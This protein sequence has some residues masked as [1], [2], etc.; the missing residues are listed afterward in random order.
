[1]G[2]EVSADDIT[3]LR[4]DLRGESSLYIE[5][6][7]GKLGL[8]CVIKRI[9]SKKTSVLPD[10]FDDIDAVLNSASGGGGLKFL[11]DFEILRRRTRIAANYEAFDD[12]AC[13]AD[14]ALKNGRHVEDTS[15]F[16]IRLRKS[17][18]AI[19]AGNPSAI[20]RLKFLYLFA[21]D[22]GYPVK[23]DFFAGLSGVEKRLFAALVRTP[24]AELFELKA[25]SRGMLEKFLEWL[26]RSTDIIA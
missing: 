25:H 22:E 23:E 18:D 19:D 8:L 12:A 4:R 14:V 17:F 10:I 2:G 5:A 24:S 15:K 20:V 9:S 21:R 6:F 3:V 1:M 7:S 26:E 16:S 11:G 13:L